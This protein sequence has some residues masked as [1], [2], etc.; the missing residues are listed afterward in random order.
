MYQMS[1][2][3]YSMFFAGIDSSASTIEFCIYELA[4]HTEVQARLQED[5]DSA[6]VKHN[7]KVT[8]DAIM[9]MNY[10]EQVIKG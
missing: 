8:Y 7:G 1:A 9:E 6:L 10:L 2:A 5:I 3:A 4:T